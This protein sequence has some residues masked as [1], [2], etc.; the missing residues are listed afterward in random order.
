MLPRNLESK[1]SRKSSGLTH[2]VSEEASVLSPNLELKNKKKPC[3]TSSLCGCRCCPRGFS[4]RPWNPF[5]CHSQYPY[6]PSFML[7]LLP[8]ASR[9]VFHGPIHRDNQIST[10]S[11][12]RM[13]SFLSFLFTWFVAFLSTITCFIS[14]KKLNN[15]DDFFR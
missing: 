4:A 11:L 3:Q 10:K 12:K 15:N 7:M 13:F 6:Y 2:A 14:R 5:F 9:F 8:A 1:S